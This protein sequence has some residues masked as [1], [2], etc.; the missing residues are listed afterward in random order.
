MT[1]A[2]IREKSGSTRRCQRP[3]ASMQ[4]IP[5]NSS[6]DFNAFYRAYAKP[7]KAL[8]HRRCRTIDPDDVVQD[9]FL[10]ALEDK[11]IV[12][13]LNPQSYL[14]RIVSNLV[15][16]E[17]RKTRVRTRFLEDEANHLLREG[18]SETESSIQSR[19]E[20]KQVY[21]LLSDLPLQVRSVFALHYIYGQNQ[22]EISA[23]LG[24]TTRTVNRYLIRI[25]EAI[26]NGVERKSANDDSGSA[27]NSGGR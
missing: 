11:A 25:R 2:A 5:V 6:F 7:A 23:C 22:I 10:R 1:S 20:L 17:Y 4:K 15:I 13:A 26:V 3:R 21:E 24:V 12:A 19:L 9:A 27:S 14:Y 16:D 8:A 18:P